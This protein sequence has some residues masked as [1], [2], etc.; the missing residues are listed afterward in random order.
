MSSGRAPPRP[1]F[2]V[3]LEGV[4][5]S[6]KTTLAR[7]LAERLGERGHTVVTTRE[8]TDGPFGRRIRAL[9]QAG[10]RSEVSPEEELELFQKDRA[11]H[12]RGLVLPALARGEVV[13]QDRSYFSTVAYQSE[14][15]LDPEALL[16]AGEAIAPRPDLLLV[17]DVPAEVAVARI[18]GSRGGATDDFETLEALRRVR[19]V[20]L[21][22][23]GAVVLDG[24]LPPEQVEAEALSALAHSLAASPSAPPDPD[25]S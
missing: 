17:V 4:D 10:R 7:A 20:F 19:Q 15:G 1:G 11:E 18:R 23:A 24:T 22:F 16:A 3:V 6:G 8:P 12:V 25:R 2:L 5:G 9:A 13:I 14:R 21:G